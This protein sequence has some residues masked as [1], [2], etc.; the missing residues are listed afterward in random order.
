MYP[1]SK[2]QETG[3][4]EREQCTWTLTLYVTGTEWPHALTSTEGD[5]YFNWRFENQVLKIW[6]HSCV[7]LD[8]GIFEELCAFICRPDHTEWTIITESRT[9][10]AMEIIWSQCSRGHAVTFIHQRQGERAYH[11]WQQCQSS[12]HNTLTCAD[13]WC[14]LVNHD[15]LKR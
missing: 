14:W 5:L 3:H 10:S 11:N 8:L 1:L 7:N 12:N 9:L 4:G 13:P 15:V 2:S 6:M